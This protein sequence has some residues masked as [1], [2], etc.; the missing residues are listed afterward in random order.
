[1]GAFSTRSA[2]RHGQLNQMHHSDSSSEQRCLHFHEHHLIESSRS[3]VQKN[4]RS[5]RGYM[6][7]PFRGV[8]GVELD[9]QQQSHNSHSSMALLSNTIVPPT[10]DSVSNEGN[11][12]A[13]SPTT[14]ILSRI[15]SPANELKVLG[16]RLGQAFAAS[17]AWGLR[18]FC[19]GSTQMSS[20]LNTDI[21][22][23]GSDV[24]S[25]GRNVAIEPQLSLCA[26]QPVFCSFIYNGM[27]SFSREHGDDASSS[28]ELKDDDEVTNLNPIEHLVA[29][30]E[31][32]VGFTCGGG[33]A[34]SYGNHHRR[35][36]LVVEKILLKLFLTRSILGVW[37][38]EL[39]PPPPPA[40][41]SA[42][43]TGVFFNNRLQGG[44]PHPGIRKEKRPLPPPKFVRRE[45]GSWQ[46]HTLPRRPPTSLVE[47][48]LLYHME[49]CKS[50]CRRPDG[51]SCGKKKKPPYNNNTLLLSACVDF[52][53]TLYE[54]APCAFLD[55]A[56]ATWRR[57]L[58]TCGDDDGTG[59]QEA[60]LVLL[61]DYIARASGC[62]HVLLDVACSG[63]EEVAQDLREHGV[64][65]VARG[66]DQDVGVMFMRASLAIQTV[67]FHFRRPHLVPS[68]TVREELLKQMS[69]LMK[70]LGNC[71]GGGAA[72][73]V[74]K[75]PVF[76]TPR[77]STRD[78]AKSEDTPIP[79][80]L[81][82]D[83]P[84]QEDDTT[85]TTVDELVFTTATGHTMC[86]VFHWTFLC[87]QELA[88]QNAAGIF[89]GGV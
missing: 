75:Y 12:P 13:S 29:V 30:V 32:D 64:E 35:V 63:M 19:K 18:R 25:G 21:T 39:P 6:V 34:T 89:F 10:N 55:V 54:S 69:S 5:A 7:S 86:N 1:M 43:N 70:A 44:G 15:A 66:L 20:T 50:S 74:Y 71:K 87:L 40:S 88:G 36:H 78:P 14:I 62:S 52:M 56:D 58:Q 16:N 27:P 48:S 24:S 57:Q 33:C 59:V 26:Q 31:F 67:T 11:S 68:D 2:R 83:L 79:F 49:E 42:T 37:G 41:S 82:L 23:G 46:A 80:V 38:S 17:H 65:S 47:R 81:V 45:D 8:R 22:A 28:S 53:N 77:H 84:P 61:S 9:D 4:S 3:T 73:D 85:T 60:T 76:M 72:D 51:D